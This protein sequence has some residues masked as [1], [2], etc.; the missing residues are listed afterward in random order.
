MRSDP[1]GGGKVMFIIDCLRIA[2]T[3]IGY[4]VMLMWLLGA[5][6]CGDFA[7]MFRMH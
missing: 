3:V 2:A 5:A 6:G 4:L 1:G 7:L